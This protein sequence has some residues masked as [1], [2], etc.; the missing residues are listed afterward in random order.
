MQPQWRVK[1]YVIAF[2]HS[3][4]CWGAVESRESAAGQF[5]EETL[6]NQMREH[7]LTNPGVEVPEAAG[8]TPRQREAWHFHVLHADST[9]QIGI[10]CH[11][12]S[13]LDFV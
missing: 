3:P 12:A 4:S 8:L 9:K 7:A 1:V 10:D 5:G 13:Y 11:S 6:P 2:T